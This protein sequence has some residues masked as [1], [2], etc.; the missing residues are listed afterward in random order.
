MK[1][2]IYIP[3]GDYEIGTD[4]NIGSFYDLEG[5]R[6]KVH[7][8]AFYIDKTSVT[9]EEFMEFVKETG[10]ITDAERYGWSYVF[11]YFLSEEIKEKSKQVAGL[12]WWYAVNGANFKHPEG[13]GSNIL[14]RLDHPVVH[15]SRNDALAYCKWANKRLPTE[16]EWEVAAKGGTNYTK[17]YWGEDL[18]QDGVHHINVWQGAFPNINTKEDGYASTAP[19]K[20]FEPNQYGI[21]Q[22]LGNVWEWCLNPRRVQ[23]TYFNENSIEEIELNHSH[24][25]NENYAIKGGSFL[26]HDTYC[27]R[28]R[29]AARTG[30]TAD[31]TTNHMGF[32]CVR[33]AK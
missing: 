31:S 6:T 7:L 8:N 32:R 26:C 11:H 9:N 29:I 1:K 30:N 25:S 18:E 16:A 4:E 24:I 13:K 28:Y 14:D 27:K 22:M 10:Y 12:D 33:T 23:L 21:Y 3:E 15:V 17:F 5:P 20:A 19:V 2:M